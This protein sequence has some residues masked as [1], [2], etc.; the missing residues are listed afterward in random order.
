[1]AKG[2]ELTRL[3]AVIMP[4]DV[5]PGR[6]WLQE[7]RE[8]L[9]PDTALLGPVERGPWTRH[10]PGEY[11]ISRL[12][13]LSGSHA[14]L[15]RQGD[16]IHAEGLRECLGILREGHGASSAVL[17]AI[18]LRESPSV[19]SGLVRELTAFGGSLSVDDFLLGE[20]DRPF[21]VPLSG[22]LLP[23]QALRVAAPTLGRLAASPW[24]ATTL[25]TL[26]GTERILQGKEPL[27]TTDLPRLPESSLSI[28]E[29]GRAEYFLTQVPVCR[30]RLVKDRLLHEAASLLARDV[31][32]S[33]LARIISLMARLAGGGPGDALGLAVKVLREVGLR[34]GLSPSGGGR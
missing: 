25:L 3:T 27:V 26:P 21:A 8:T 34:A 17:G 24:F 12:P 4:S 22:I 1:M 13:E 10:A 28:D 20:I 19:S 7:T 30:D 23:A 32:P 9:G 5:S 18:A 11:L 16:R 15:L 29:T 33:R 14:L 2:A 6:E 31:R